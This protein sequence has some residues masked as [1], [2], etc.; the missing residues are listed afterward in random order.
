MVHEELDEYAN[1]MKETCS[2][3]RRHLSERACGPTHAMIWQEIVTQAA[4][5]LSALPTREA[6]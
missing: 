1:Q 3:C 5:H 6:Q 4:A 2:Q